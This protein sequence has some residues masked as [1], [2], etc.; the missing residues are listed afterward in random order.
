MVS[1]TCYNLLGITNSSATGIFSHTNCVAPINY[2]Q[3]GSQVRHTI[4][5][6]WSSV[7]AMNG[8]YKLPTKYQ[9]KKKIL[10]EIC[11]YT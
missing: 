5:G 9:K 1:V 8:C 11:Q 6:N 10:K 7:V 3:I 4:F 2:R